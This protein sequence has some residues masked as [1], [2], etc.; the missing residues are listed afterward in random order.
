MPEDRTS[1]DDARTAPDETSA[2]PSHD[3]PVSDPRSETSPESESDAASSATQTATELAATEPAATESNTP[4]P[5]PDETPS[6]TSNGNAPTPV[7]EP[8]SEGTVATDAGSASNGGQQSPDASDTSGAADTS[9]TKPQDTD[10]S[11]ESAE[12]KGGGEF[13]ELLDAS[14]AEPREVKVG[15]RV[16]GKIVK[17]NDDYAFIDY[18]GRA[19]ARIATS[20]LRDRDGKVLM[21]V[22]DMLTA[23][24]SAVDEAVTLTLGKR[25]GAVSAARLREAYE[26]KIPVS[27]NVKSVNKGGFDVS[28]GG[29]RAF[30]PLSQVDHTYVD[31]PEEYVGKTFRFRVL[32]WE[33]GGR[34]IVVSRRPILREQAKQRATETRKSLEV[35]AEFDGV[36][37]RLQ[38]FG[39]FVD[40]G[41]LEGLLHVSRMGHTRVEDP[42]TVVSKGDKVR[43]RVV[44]IENPGTRKERI[45]LSLVDLGPDPWDSVPDTLKD[46]DILTGTVARLVPFGA[47][48]RLPN[49]MDGLVHVSE[50]SDKRIKTPEEAVTQ[51]QEVQVRVLRVDAEKKR[52]SLS[53]RLSAEPAPSRPKPKREPRAA[54][55]A[56]KESKGAPS[57]SGPVSLTHTMADQLGR[58]K[59]KLRDPD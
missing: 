39:A 58:L 29:I 31:K 10:A 12:T 32:R 4:K 38:P 49:G 3:K 53:L 46:G 25:R 23:T 7:A 26:N 59:D 34:N 55:G 35:G 48:V 36:V 13:A 27:G 15:D 22:D 33:N 14:A 24:V 30:C 57:P 20:E 43:V 37:T 41:G 54:R 8:S 2:T 21:R 16:R 47:F 51:G 42:S 50:L 1:P 40:L 6:E 18:K 28:V 56:P 52:I 44:N 45:A 19:E 5:T 17:L 9:Q 11:A